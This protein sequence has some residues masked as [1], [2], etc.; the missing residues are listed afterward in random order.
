MLK[1]CYTGTYTSNQ[2]TVTESRSNPFPLHLLRKLEYLSLL[3]YFH[4]LQN[5]GSARNHIECMHLVHHTPSFPHSHLGISTQ[6][7]W[8]QPPFWMIWLWTC[9]TSLTAA[10]LAQTFC[11]LIKVTA[12][13]SALVAFQRHFSEQFHYLLA[14]PTF[15]MFR[16]H[17]I[18]SNPTLH[19]HLTQLSNCFSQQCPYFS[20][21]FLQ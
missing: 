9:L 4:A 5:D 11:I 8:T 17:A 15:H 3:P 10:T 21:E 18:P 1:C 12:C 20:H 19:G 13:S 7:H 14:F 16:N 2:Q 6:W